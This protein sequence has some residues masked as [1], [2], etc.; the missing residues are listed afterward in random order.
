[1]CI[2]IH[3]YK[4][5]LSLS[6]NMPVLP[7]CPFDQILLTCTSN[8]TFLHWLI[9]DTEGAVQESRRVANDVTN[10]PSLTVGSTEFHF[11]LSSPLRTLPYISQLQANSVANGT[12]I[13]CSESAQNQGMNQNSVAIC[14]IQGNST[15][16]NQVNY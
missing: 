1:M 4:A 7:L 11:T 14:I 8:T 13:S 6:S 12:V 2:A 9:M 15:C 16:G 3:D 10:S 5:I